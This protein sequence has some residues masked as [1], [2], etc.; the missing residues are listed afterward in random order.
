MNI[1]LSDSRWPLDRVT[2]DN[3]ALG[4]PRCPCAAGME[5]VSGRPGTAQCPWCLCRTLTLGK[6]GGD[7]SLSHARGVLG[8]VP[9]PKAPSHLRLETRDSAWLG[10]GLQRRWSRM[11]SWVCLDGRSRQLQAWWPEGRGAGCTGRHCRVPECR[12]AAVGTGGP[13][14]P[15]RAALASMCEPGS[16]PSSE[17]RTQGMAGSPRWGVDPCSAHSLSPRRGA[18]VA[19]APCWPLCGGTPAHTTVRVGLGCPLVGTGGSTAPCPVPALPRH[20]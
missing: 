10:S 16:V 15:P 6:A 12:C 13:G 19:K 5:A 8:T 3:A 17:A 4:E 1:T 9:V 7:R 18:S 11:S 2:P 14:R 20:C